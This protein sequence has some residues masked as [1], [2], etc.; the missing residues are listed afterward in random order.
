MM[1]GPINIR[2]III[3]CV[4]III[5]KSNDVTIVLA[6]VDHLQFI[7]NVKEFFFWLLAVF[8]II[9]WF[10]LNN[11]LYSWCLFLLAFTTFMLFITAIG[12]Y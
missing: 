2:Y 5:G 11:A 8:F 3:I 1:H 10:S 7:A 12:H 6:S 9:L 4:Y